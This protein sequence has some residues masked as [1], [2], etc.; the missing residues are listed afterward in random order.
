[1]GERVNPN[2]R[3]ESSVISL[4]NITVTDRR[5]SSEG[6]RVVSFHWGT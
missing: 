6:L 5:A 2:D 3:F 4:G 1:M